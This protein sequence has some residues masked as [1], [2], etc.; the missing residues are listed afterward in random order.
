M[1]NFISFIMETE[2]GYDTMIGDRGG[3]L[4]G[5]QRQRVSILALY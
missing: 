2:K 5:G 4:S 1:V 3:R